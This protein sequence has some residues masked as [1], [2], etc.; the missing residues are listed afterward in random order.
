MR[1]SKTIMLATIFS[2]AVAGVCVAGAP[3]ID[4]AARQP[5]ANSA[6]K[7][8]PHS[9]ALKSHSP[10]PHTRKTIYAG[11]KVHLINILAP[12]QALPVQDNNISGNGP[13]PG[14]G[15][16]ENGFN[17]QNCGTSMSCGNE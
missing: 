3:Q 16:V 13:L 15:S 5:I 2:S 7:S 17:K 12:K 11:K 4:T 8:A 9:S 6:V 10:S 14:G 1:I